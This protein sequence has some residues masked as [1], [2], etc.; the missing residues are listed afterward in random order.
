MKSVVIHHNLNTPGGEATLAIETIQCLYELGYDVELITVQKPD[1]EAI[2]KA[3]GKK[4]PIKKTKALFP[5]KLNYFGI[6]QK[7]LTVMPSL[8]IADADFVINTNGNTLPYNVPK[9]LP[10]ILYLHFPTSL[11]R[12]PMYGNNK[13]QR[14][15]F[16]KAYFRPYQVMEKVL[17]K[18][19]LE[20]SRMVL[21]NSRFSSD[22]IRKAY[23]GVN[24]YVLYP[25]VDIERFSR[26]YRSQSRERQVLVISRF[27]P[28][29]GIEK[30]I[31]IAHLLGNV[32]F[33][34]IGSL[35]PA[36]RSYFNSL[37]ERIR[38]Y[39]LEN[40]IR[41]TPNAT[42]EEIIDTMSS[43]MVYL[44]T[45]YG[46]HFGVSVIEAMAAGLLPIVP[47]Y[48]GCS[49]ITPQEYHYST[50]EDAADCISKNIAEYNGRK[51]ERLYD[52]V[53]QFSTSAFRKRMQQYIGQAC[54]TRS[55]NSRNKSNEREPLTH[56]ST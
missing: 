49:E 8:G 7:L 2:A 11:M 54:Y 32:N 19:S 37:K 14:S 23:S 15:L 44:H 35:L 51:L 55:N 22:A 41:L 12:S 28:E 45:M 36:N 1:L 31:K 53:R 48:G 9:H 25:P 52:I 30:A 33:E 13:Y 3:Y 21:T 20:R 40:R 43:S 34:I 5:F 50:V 6:Y 56:G 47:Y 29:K 10:S 27:S 4:I 42:N 18:R 26:A 16:W 17:A 39:R 46:E 38:D 24:P